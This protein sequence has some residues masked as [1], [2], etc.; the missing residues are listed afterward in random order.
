M[1]VGRLIRIKA[2]LEMPETGCLIVG[3]PRSGT[4]LCVSMVGAHPEIAMTSEDLCHGA[5]KA[6]GVSVWGNKLTVP[7]HITLDPEAD[8]RSYWKRLED[9]LRGFLGRPRGGRQLHPSCQTTIRTYVE[10]KDAHVIGMI[11]SPNQVVDSIIHRGNQSAEEAKRRWVRAVRAI[12]TVVQ[13]Y[14]S[15]SYVVRFSDL[16][17][18]PE[19]TMG[20]ICAFLNVSFSSDM[21]DG[22]KY[23]PQYDRDDIDEER[24]A[25]EVKDYE[26]QKYD[27]DAVK[28]YR[29]LV[30]H[31]DELK[32]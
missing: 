28:M 32:T 17:R 5:Q 10:E 21:L 14:P 26:V 13:D 31:A 24:A 1:F 15:R 4:T 25:A 2:V 19:Q 16:V 30:E 20:R 3:S 22:F 23:T 18:V 12:R 29:Q 7:N 27:W 8:T 9:G 6:V 11:R